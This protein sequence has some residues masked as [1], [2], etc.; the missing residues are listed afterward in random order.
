MTGN[1][2]HVCRASVKWVCDHHDETQSQ[3]SSSVLQA[4][5]PK[6]HTVDKSGKLQT[7]EGIA[8]D[9]GDIENVDDKA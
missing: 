8:A 5:V 9:N 4:K 1:R 3:A 6:N 2:V 7:A